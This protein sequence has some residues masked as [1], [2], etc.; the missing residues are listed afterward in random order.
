MWAAKLKILLLALTKIK[1]FGTAASSHRLHRRLRPA[2]GLALRGDRRR[3]LFVHELGHVVALR[4]EG[5]PASA[6][7]FIP[8]LGAYV[9]LKR[10]PQD[11]WVEAKVGLAGPVFGLVSSVAVLAAAMALDS[12]LL[13]G[14]AYFG[15][16]I[17]LFNLIPLTPLDGGRAA[18]AASTPTSGSRARSAWCCCSSSSRARS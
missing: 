2:L 8:F 17:N 13:R 1:Y 5:I 16:F 18:A 3:L 12:D 4:R 11:A 9:T 6:P 14:A 7:M 10:M 15:F